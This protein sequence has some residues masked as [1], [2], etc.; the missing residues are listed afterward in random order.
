MA[1]ALKYYSQFRTIGNLTLCR[2]ELHLK[3]YAGASSS[4]SAVSTD[5]VEINAAGAKKNDFKIIQGTEFLFNFYSTVADAGKYEELFE[6]EYKDWKVYYYVNSVLKFVGY[7]KPE[8]FQRVFLDNKYF[9]TLSATDALADLKNIPYPATSGTVGILEVIKTAL[10]LIDIPLDFLIQLNTY[11]SALST[12]TE[13][14]VKVTTI[15]IERFI[16]EKDGYFFNTNCHE[17]IEAMLADFDVTFR[18]SNGFYKITNTN[19]VDS[20]VYRFTYSTLVQVSRTANDLVLNIDDF[21]YTNRG[22]LNKIEPVKFANVTYQNRNLGGN[23]L[24][25]SWTNTGWNFFNATKEG[26]N[27]VINATVGSDGYK[28]GT[29]AT[30]YIEKKSDED[31]LLVRFNRKIVGLL[32]STGH[33]PHLVVEYKTGIITTWTPITGL[34][35]LDET[36]RYYEVQIP[37]DATSSNYQIRFAIFVVA[38]TTALTVQITDMY[39]YPVYPDEDITFDKLFIAENSGTTAIKKIEETVYFGDGL[40]SNDIGNFKY[41]TTPLTSQWSRYGKTDNLP[42]VS[43]HAL[44]ILNNNAKYR[45]Y[46]SID[47]YDPGFAISEDGILELDSRY[48]TFIGF[49]R[50]YMSGVLTAELIEKLVDDITYP[51]ITIHNLTSVDGKSSGSSDGT[52]TPPSYPIEYT[53]GSGLR[54]VGYEGRLGDDNITE[55]ID[56]LFNGDLTY[57][58]RVL[59][60]SAGYWYSEWLMEKDWASVLASYSTTSGE[61][62]GHFAYY[63][64]VISTIQASVE[65]AAATR[66]GASASIKVEADGNIYI[67]G[68]VGIGDATPSYKL[69]VN[70]TG[71]FVQDLTCDA[72]FDA[73]SVTTPNVDIDTGG[74]YVID[75][76][77]TISATD[78]RATSDIRYKKNIEPIVGALDILTKL[79]GY[80]YQLKENGHEDFGLIAQ[81]VEKIIKEP[82]SVDDGGKYS[83]NYNSFI[84]LLIEAVKELNTRLKLLEHGSGK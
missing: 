25:N 2:V 43:L 13:C 9:I 72:D 15:P 55:D 64:V 53:F 19:E 67:R 18:Q 68:D 51:S 45:N 24:P 1:H 29:S 26:V 47:I 36:K 34:L 11:E 12:T 80:H 31:Y 78:F 49:T 20:Y 14:A 48:Y 42:I 6:S 62:D 4:I 21:N 50:K 3:D 60:N 69:D 76:A 71:R 84:A 16:E 35:L 38:G 59:H 27:M 74:T 65:M 81:F 44:T 77:G 52:S 10:D 75:A 58:T 79:Q 56:L 83:L 41:G 33:E 46:L 66:G 39:G 63:E 70:G 23:I 28:Y 57:Y 82:V 37:V 5:P 32:P 54:Q 7:V 22:T 61:T 17:V 40:Q 8:N 73:D 30:F